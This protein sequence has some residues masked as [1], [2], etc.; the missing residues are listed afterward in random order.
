[1]ELVGRNSALATED[2]LTLHA[3]LLLDVKV[4]PADG[5]AVRGA[6]PAAAAA[7]TGRARPNPDGPVGHGCAPQPLVA[8]RTPAEP[9]HDDDAAAALPAYT[10]V[11]TPEA[12]HAAVADLRA[13]AAR[14]FAVDCEGVDLGR[15][16]SITLLQGAPNS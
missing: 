12:L 8:E 4:M 11:D 2:T 3:R 7:L 5:S 14:T 15:D 6:A 10:L 16:G 1:V 13:D 9:T